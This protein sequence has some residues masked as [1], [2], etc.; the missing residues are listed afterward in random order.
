MGLFNSIDFSSVLSDTL[1]GLIVTGVAALASY[2]FV[3]RYADSIAF[4]KKME[5]YGFTQFTTGKQTAKEVLDMCERATLIKIINVSGFHY[6]N[7]NEIMLRRALERGAEVRFLCARPNSQFLRDIEEMEF[8]TLNASGK[9]IRERDSKITS[10][11][12]DLV[13]KYDNL[14][15]DI[16]FYNTQY[17]LPYVIAYYP[18]N[19]VKVWLTMTLP[20]YKSTKAFIL[21]GNADCDRIYHEEANFVE[22]IETNFDTI[23]SHGS[24]DAKEYDFACE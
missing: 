7:S 15:L 18:D 22:M 12:I 2:L 3:S 4:S 13:K 1:S 24:I 16:R 21:R 6:L 19:S 20:P 17:R 8:H 9:R 5:S 23:W 10:E 11:I 14:G